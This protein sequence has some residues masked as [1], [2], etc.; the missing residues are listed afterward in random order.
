MSPAFTRC[1]TVTR[2]DH[3]KINGLAREDARHLVGEIV[4]MA[5]ALDIC[6]ENQDSVSLVKQH[7]AGLS[8]AD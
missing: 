7:L 1:P 4:V 6:G 8:A 5:K 3:Y 2:N